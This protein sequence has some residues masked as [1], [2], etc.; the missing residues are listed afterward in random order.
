MF[1]ELIS[2]ILVFFFVL[3]LLLSTSII[4]SLHKDIVEA[5]LRWPF[6][7]LDLSLWGYHINPLRLYS[8]LGIGE[9]FRP[10]PTQLINPFSI[11]GSILVRL[12][13]V[14]SHHM[15]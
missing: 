3:I 7:Y 14:N 5:S 10:N 11:Q 6:P 8:D 1:Y 12:F 9:T 2:L 13:S 4:W 15:I